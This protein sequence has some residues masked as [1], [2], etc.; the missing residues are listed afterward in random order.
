MVPVHTGDI[1]RGTL[2]KIVRECHEPLATLRGRWVA[3]AAER[4]W[5]VRG[6]FDRMRG[7]AGTCEELGSDEAAKVFEVL[8]GPQCLTQNASTSPEGRCRRA[9]R[10]PWLRALHLDGFAV[11][12]T[13]VI[14][15]PLL[16]LNRPARSARA[17]SGSRGQ[18]N[19]TAWA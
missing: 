2:R 1:A 18:G 19:R 10:R 13:S 4:G 3:A 17:R 15:R 7:Q 6:T 8:A 14:T 12:R 11:A 9:P 16:T 5:D